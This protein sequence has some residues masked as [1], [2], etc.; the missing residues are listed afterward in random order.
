MPDLANIPFYILHL[1]G[2][3]QMRKKFQY[4][5]N[6]NFSPNQPSFIAVSKTSRIGLTGFFGALDSR[7]IPGQGFIIQEWGWEP[8][9]EDTLLHVK[10][11]ALTQD[12]IH[13]GIILAIL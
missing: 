13:P 1:Q 4:D 9:K 2:R 10:K 5:K 8:K 7:L 12:K 3:R 11:F 6:A